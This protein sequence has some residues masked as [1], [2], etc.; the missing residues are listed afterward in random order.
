MREEEQEGMEERAGAVGI[1]DYFLKE[2]DQS[3]GTQGTCYI[4]YCTVCA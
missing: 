3:P 2:R 1:T 4:S